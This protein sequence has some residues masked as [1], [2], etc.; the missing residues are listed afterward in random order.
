MTKFIV[1]EGLAPAP[2][3]TIEAEYYGESGSF[4]NFYDSEGDPVQ[5]VRT[6]SV[7]TIRIA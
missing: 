6:D 4:T 2:E 1:N 7:F 5:A 3:L